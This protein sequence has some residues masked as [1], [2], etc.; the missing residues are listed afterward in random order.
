[1]P[2][3]PVQLIAAF[4]ASKLHFYGS[5]LSAF[6]A[7][8]DDSRGTGANDSGGAGSV[9]VT[10]FVALLLEAHGDAVLAAQDAATDLNNALL[11]FR[12]SRRF[13]GGSSCWGRC[14]GW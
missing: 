12:G 6:W 7:E 4:L 11:P 8:K 9:F 2:V 1:M 5:R 13:P 14:A 3:F 10:A